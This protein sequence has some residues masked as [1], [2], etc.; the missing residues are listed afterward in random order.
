MQGRTAVC[1]LFEVSVRLVLNPITLMKIQTNCKTM[2]CILFLWMGLVACT[3]D[4]KGTNIVLTDGTQTEQTVYA[5]ET[6]GNPG[7]IHFTAMADWTATVT[8]VATKAEGGSTVDWLTLSAYGGG[9]GEY[10]LTLTLTENTTGQDRKAKIEIRCG[11]DVITITV[12]QKGVTEEGDKPEQPTTPQGRRLARMENT[13]VSSDNPDYYEKYIMTFAYDAEGRLAEFHNISYRGDGQSYYT[14]E[15][16]TFTYT[17]GQVEMAY[18][19]SGY[20]DRDVYIAKLNEAGDV[21][22]LYEEPHLTTTTAWMFQYDAEGYLQQILEDNAYEVEDEEG[23]DEDDKVESLPSPG[24]DNADTRAFD[25][26]MLT[27]SWRNGNLVSTHDDD[28]WR[29]EYLMEWD[30]TAYTNDTPDLD[31]NVLNRSLF[32]NVEN[33]YSTWANMLFALR[34]LGKGSKNLVDKNLVNWSYESGTPEPAIETTHHDEWAPYEYTFTA[35][36]Y[37][38]RVTAR[39]T[40]RTVT[41]DTAT[42]EVISESTSYLDDEYIFVYE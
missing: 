11:G 23:T 4:E 17:D 22:L 32:G 14:D 30:Y 34:M 40:L 37:L 18:E 2:W 25:F 39:C 31:F 41:T 12:E 38:Q 20:S 36:N 19:E 5:D 8:L 35:E 1:K 10:I 6:T 7:G 26:P 42:G 9:P 15:V 29:E 33:T 13:C 21:C 16:C 27:L 3:D 24:W 28:S